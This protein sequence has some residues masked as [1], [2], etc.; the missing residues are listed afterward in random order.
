MV[1]GP[2]CGIGVGCADGGCEDLMP[3]DDVLGGPKC[4]GCGWELADVAALD[5]DTTAELPPNTDDEFGMPTL[6]PGGG[7]GSKGG[8]VA[9]APVAPTMA[10]GE[11]ALT[12]APPIFGGG[13]K[14]R[15]IPDPT[16]PP[17][18]RPV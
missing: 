16:A 11:V 3:S 8:A 6:E 18:E 12:P 17:L 9:V 1:D 14:L 4:G 2:G 7:G 10:L 13:A 5:V 15:P